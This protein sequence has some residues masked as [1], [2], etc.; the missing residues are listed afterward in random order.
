M[1]R[2]RRGI[3]RFTGGRSANGPRVRRVRSWSAGLGL[4]LAVLAA[5]IATLGATSASAW[6][7]YGT[8]PECTELGEEQHLTA[9]D[10]VVMPSTTTYFVYWQPPGAPAFP[11]GYESGIT[12]FF[13][14]LEHD[15]G[16]DQNFYSVLTQYGVRYETHFGKALTDKDPYPAESPECAAEKTPTKPCVTDLQI[17][18]ELKSLVKGDELPDQ[19]FEQGQEPF[20][21]PTHA[22][23]VLLPPGVS[24]CDAT[25]EEVNEQ[26]QKS[27]HTGY[28]CSLVQFCS[29]HQSVR[30]VSESEALTYAA[31]PYVSG[32][33]A[34][35]DTQHPNGVSDGE[36]PFMEHE[37]A[38]MITDP[39]LIGWFNAPTVGDE[40]VADICDG[41]WAFGNEA[42]AQKMK[43]GTPLG[44][45][46]NG[47]LY[48]QVINGRDYWL[49][50][51][52]SNATETC[53]QRKALP[54]VVS[55]L[56]TP[57]GPE[58][59]GTTV[60]IT[61]LN[62]K[63][64][65][66]TAVKF[67]NEPATSFSV[68]S[69]KSLKA[70]VP[71]SSPGTVDITLT[72]EAGQSVAV[73][74]DRFTFTPP[75]TVSSVSPNTGPTAGGTSVTVK[76]TNFLVGSSATKFRFDTAMATAVNCISTTECTM[77][78]PARTRGTINVIAT[79]DTLSSPAVAGD[80]YKY[81]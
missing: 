33:T 49:A 11:A 16:G 43:W 29:Y 58:T 38:E 31:M 27:L 73:S 36:L 8:S 52:Y 80:R 15:N 47:A 30:S 40:E 1:S 37:F 17:Q 25:R 68:A 23:F 7:C 5:L 51:M 81:S 3:A 79:V 28:G 54:P 19:V 53:V 48:N 60:T 65:E 9:T 45:A 64:P 66:V 24:V 70:V 56:S 21:G 39:L 12:T 61:G 77:L 50:Q 42:F 4:L 26:G 32:M 2:S 59:G 76:G 67:G 46:P 44:T 14:G 74:A 63:A 6:E 10:P 71:A 34:C 62:F 35:E 22:Y 20:S 13:K 18:A 57:T 55:A 75:P 69:A 78:S 41:R 72:N